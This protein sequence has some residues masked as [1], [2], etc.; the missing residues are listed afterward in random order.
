MEEQNFN[1][2]IN[3]GVAV[4]DDKLT[5]SIKEI[6]S[7]LN[8]KELEKKLTDATEEFRS[9]LASL[10]GI[11]HIGYYD[12]C[13]T[14]TI[15][16]NYKPQFVFSPRA[17]SDSILIELGSFDDWPFIGMPKG[18]LDKLFSIN[19]LEGL[20]K[21]F[22]SLVLHAYLPN[23]FYGRHNKEKV[24]SIITNY[25][26]KINNPSLKDT[27]TKEEK[28]EYL[29][30]KSTQSFIVLRK[31][32]YDYYKIVSERHEEI[33]DWMKNQKIRID[34]NEEESHK[35]FLYIIEKQLLSIKTTSLGYKD[36]ERKVETQKR[37]TILEGLIKKYKKKYP[38]DDMEFEYEL[39]NEVTNILDRRDDFTKLFGKR[40]DI[41]TLLNIN[42]NSLNEMRT[43]SMK[44]IEAQLQDLLRNLPYLKQ[45]GVLPD[46]DKSLTFEENK[47]RVEDYISNLLNNTINEEK[48]HGA[49]D[50]TEEV[51]N[52]LEELR[53]E[54]KS[55]NIT[56]KEIN[57]K[58]I[59]IKKIEMVLME[60]KP[61]TVHKAN[62][63]MGNKMDKSKVFNNYYAYY[64]PNGM[65][66]LDRVDGY[67]ALYI[68]PVH[69][70]REAK[71]KKN[72][73]E[74]RNIPGV[75]YISHKREKWLEDAKKY[76]E[77]GSEGLTEEEIKEEMITASTDFPFTLEKLEK[78]KA[79]LETEG[80][81]T[82]SM[83]KAIKNKAQEI[84]DLEKIDTELKNEKYEF[85]S[86]DKS[87]EELQNE[88]V[89]DDYI[90]PDE[91]FIDSYKAEQQGKRKG[92]YSDAV[93]R[94]TKRRAMDSHGDYCCEL[95]DTKSMDA[96]A[97][98]YHHVIPLS[99]GGV[100][101]I[102]NTVCLCPGC[103]NYVHS[104]KLVSSDMYRMLMAIK[105]HLLED[106]KEYLPEFLEMVKEKYPIDSKDI[107]DYKKNK[108]QIDYNFAIQWNND[109]RIIK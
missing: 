106:R 84:K 25:E 6:N 57:K 52:K 71:Y 87:Y 3:L 18:A 92:K 22:P 28:A 96:G 100:D 63:D 35:L 90:D 78:M 61:K 95:C 86:D 47:K 13:L 54:I 21:E 94:E 80:K 20:K 29:K 10:T 107:E 99:E 39:Y 46:V 26:N 74:V 44:K 55:G 62:S 97:F 42:R 40:K 41:F 31:C 45:G 81:F 56:E 17:Y 34:L 24:S 76:L 49:K 88:E 67:G 16:N 103:H 1:D 68:M 108:E 70:Y 98:H 43:I 93:R 85:T 4:S 82:K 12:T 53:D 105:G 7:F 5:L 69:I 58:K 14:I 19:D 89:K 36:V 72:L 60:I 11:N 77:E 79:E 75:K 33:R 65:V 27:I 91:S 23:Y 30:A 38:N 9:Y 104:N 8:N 102:Y 48:E 50:V 101:N 59:I 32:I 51:N 37:F 83:A 109:P 66:A 2:V 15:D 64:Y 73:T